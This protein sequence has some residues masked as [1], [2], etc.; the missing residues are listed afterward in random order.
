MSTHQQQLQIIARLI[1]NAEIRLKQF[2]EYPLGD[3]GEERRFGLDCE[4]C[5]II[6][7][8][9]DPKGSESMEVQAVRQYQNHI[10]TKHQ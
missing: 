7:I 2:G 9:L 3:E 10:T 6:Y 4:D 8:R 1:A 5:G